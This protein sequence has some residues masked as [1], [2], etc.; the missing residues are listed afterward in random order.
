MDLSVLCCLC[1]MAHNG[2]LSKLTAS[3]K[4]AGTSTMAQCHYGGASYMLFGSDIIMCPVKHVAD[5]LLQARFQCLSLL[6]DH[7]QHLRQQ[8]KTITTTSTAQI[9]AWQNTCSHKT[10]R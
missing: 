3:W 5:V 4:Q 8:R 9:A 10:I 2:E 7:I 1:H 6:F